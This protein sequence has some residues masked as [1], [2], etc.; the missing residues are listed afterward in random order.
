LSDNIICILLEILFASTNL[1][2][3]LVKFFSL[4]DYIPILYEGRMH[5][6]VFYVLTSDFVGNFIICSRML[7]EESL[8]L[9]EFFLFGDH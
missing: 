4:L 8:A 3:N 1:P 2:L 6:F 9:K 5:V 7:P